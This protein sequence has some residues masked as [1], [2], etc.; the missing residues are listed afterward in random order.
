MIIPRK[1][2][3]SGE[4]TKHTGISRQTIHYY[5]QLGLIKEAERTRSGQRLFDENVF[6]VIARIR[7]YQNQEMT[8]LEIR[9]KLRNDPQLKFIF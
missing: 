3:R 2:Y 9:E 5:T 1:L 6:H 8:L 4:I 7:E